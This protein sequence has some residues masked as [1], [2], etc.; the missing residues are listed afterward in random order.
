MPFELD[1]PPALSGWRIK[2]RDRERLEPPH[3]TVLWKARAWRICLRT[4]QPLDRHPPTRLLP[5]SLLPLL[6]TEQA[7]LVAAWNRMYP[8]NPVSSDA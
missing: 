4:T 8:E 6:R 5:K 2:I 3:V 1:L 7:V